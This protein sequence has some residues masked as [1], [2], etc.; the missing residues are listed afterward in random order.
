VPEV[1]A[2]GGDRRAAARQWRPAG[3]LWRHAQRNAAEPSAR[4]RLVR[5]GKSAWCPA[6]EALL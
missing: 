2:L 5:F 4:H 6:S 1:R 3:L